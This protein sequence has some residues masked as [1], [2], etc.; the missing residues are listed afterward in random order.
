MNGSAGKEIIHKRTE[1]EI[2]EFFRDLFV[3][4]NY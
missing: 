4:S 1:K 3:Y 2:P